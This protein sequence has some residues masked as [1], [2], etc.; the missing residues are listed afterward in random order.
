MGA[1]GRLLSSTALSGFAGGWLLLA[2]GVASAADLQPLVTKAP[3]AAAPAEYLP[4]VDGLNFKA[5]GFGGTITNR[6]VYGSEGAVS[7]P[8]GGQFGLQLDGALG[9]FGNS[10]FGSGAAHAFWR[11][12]AR[13]LA[14]FYTSHTYWDQ[15]GGVHVDRYGGEGA[16]YLDRWTLEGTAGVETGSNKTVTVGSFFDT[17]A[18]KTRFYD[19]VS[20]NYYLTDNLRLSVGHAYTDGLNALTLGGE[21]GFRVSERTMGSLFIEG[22]A[23]EGDFHGVYGGLRFYFGNHDKSLI[24][25]NREDDPPS[26][27]NLNLFTLGG[28]TSQQ[29]VPPL[30]V[31]PPVCT[32][33]THLVGN[34]CV[35]NPSDRR[36][37]RDIIPL[38]RLAGGLMLYRYRYLWSDQLYVGVMAQEVAEVVPAAVLCGADGFLRVDYARLGLKLLTWDEWLQLQERQHLLLAA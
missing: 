9:D 16:L 35:P 28:A 13:G 37:K 8:L 22:R 21:W 29:G 30:P 32:G 18:I 1:R 4:A 26:D 36:L 2:G 5:D 38:Y 15:I 31:A 27:Q 7:I 19:Q 12:P 20:A 25:R 11:D 34:I 23:G 24:R 17:V 33:E 10:F 3:P 14:G 6:S